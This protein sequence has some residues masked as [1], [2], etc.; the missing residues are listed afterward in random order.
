MQDTRGHCYGTQR[1]TTRSLTLA[2]LLAGLASIARP[3]AARPDDDSTGSK[4]QSVIAGRKE[5]DK[6]GYYKFHFGEGYRK[7]WT[8]P[9]AEPVLDLEDLRRRAHRRAPGRLDAE[10]GAGAQGPGR[11]E[12]H[13]PDLRQGPDQDPAARVERVRSRRA[14]SRTRRPRAIPRR[15]SSCPSWPT[16]WA[17]RTRTRSR[18]SCRTTRRSASFAPPSAASR[19]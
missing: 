19:G 15:R 13:V 17:C 9:F 1:M 18:S 14:S 11:Q 16:R 4:T 10:P 7:L 3:E 8:T 2:A 5:Y 12:L 6:P